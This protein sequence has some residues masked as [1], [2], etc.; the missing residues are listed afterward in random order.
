[1]DNPQVLFA[2]VSIVV[3]FILSIVLQPSEL[4]PPDYFPQDG[5]SSRTDPDPR[6]QSG[7]L[8]S[9]RGSGRPTG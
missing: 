9:T 4:E 5:R 3:V 8:A 1:M 2:A 7:V 6:V